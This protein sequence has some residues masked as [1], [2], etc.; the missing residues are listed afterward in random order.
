MSGL[1]K[2][3]VEVEVNSSR[4]LWPHLSNEVNAVGFLYQEIVIT[5]A[6]GEA[7]VTEVDIGAI[8]KDREA[9]RSRMEGDVGRNLG[10]WVKTNSSVWSSVLRQA[11]ICVLSFLPFLTPCGQ[12]W[13]IIR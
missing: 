10:H 12:K 13:H 11:C 2:L 9:K 4:K 7:L 1:V 6:V 8:W 5:L 3:D